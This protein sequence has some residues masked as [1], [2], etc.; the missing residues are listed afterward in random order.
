M[1]AVACDIRI[2]VNAN[3]LGDDLSIPKPYLEGRDQGESLVLHILINIACYLSKEIQR[4][5]V[6]QPYLLY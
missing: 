3:Q 4:T 6:T 1:C 2:L 5:W